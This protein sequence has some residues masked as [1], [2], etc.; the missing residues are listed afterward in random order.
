MQILSSLHGKCFQEQDILNLYHWV[1]LRS[2][3]LRI[4]SLGKQYL[5]TSF[6]QLRKGSEKLATRGIDRWGI[7]SC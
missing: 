6:Q 5:Q 7:T 3:K 4:L 2:L 1:L